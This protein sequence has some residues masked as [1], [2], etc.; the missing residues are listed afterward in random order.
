MYDPLFASHPG[1]VPAISLVHYSPLSHTHDESEYSVG[2]PNMYFPDHGQHQQQQQAY[3]FG[4]PAAPPSQ[5]L[6]DYQRQLADTPS[7]M[8]DQ[9]SPA[10]AHNENG[11]RPSFSASAGPSRKR[12]RKES[13]LDADADGGAGS[14]QDNYD[15]NSKDGKPKA[16][17]GARYVAF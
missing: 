2:G 10:A 17:R 15:P 1:F 7:S 6:L 8:E 3:P 5:M 4:A 9:M 14:P 12:I 13:D 16:T 11:K